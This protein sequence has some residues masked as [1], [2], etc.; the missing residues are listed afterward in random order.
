M[1][2]KLPGDISY[3]IYLWHMPIINVMIVS[4]ARNT[5]TH[6]LPVFLAILVSLAALSWF[7]IESPALRKARKM[8]DKPTPIAI[9]KLTS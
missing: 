7:C 4:S 1:P 2:F 5:S 9:Q 8:R 6:P 3:G